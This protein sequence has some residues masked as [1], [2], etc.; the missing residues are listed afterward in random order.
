MCSEP[1]LPNG[2]SLEPMAR[3]DL[4]DVL[5]IEE[6]SFLSPWSR[7]LFTGE[8][9]TPA[10]RTLTIRLD[11]R[12]SRVLAGYAVFRLAADEMDILKIAVK[13]EFRRRGLATC[14]MK[15][16]IQSARKEQCVKVFLEVRRSN[17]AAIRLYEK[18]GFVI[19]GVRRLYYSEQGED[20]LVMGMDIPLQNGSSVR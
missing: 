20:A 8:L 9:S 12:G 4:D 7:A 14:L 16:L 11:R 17:A 3:G 6:V 2:F 1:G 13:P 19:Q 10:S 5:A 15:A 18:L